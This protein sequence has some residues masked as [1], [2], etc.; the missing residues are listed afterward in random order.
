ME[1]DEDMRDGF[2]ITRLLSKAGF[3][4]YCR[5]YEKIVIVFFSVRDRLP[6]NL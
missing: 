2:N 6:H 4:I 5:I 3:H 1:I